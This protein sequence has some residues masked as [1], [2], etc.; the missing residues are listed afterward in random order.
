MSYKFL[1]IGYNDKYV[2][3]II[4]K[5]TF[6]GQLNIAN[7]VK[8]SVVYSWHFRKLLLNIGCELPPTPIV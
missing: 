6:I 8:D 3:N 5:N 7:E 1:F 4:N 2:K